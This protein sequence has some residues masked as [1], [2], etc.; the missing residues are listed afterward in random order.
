[1]DSICFL[2]LSR[3]CRASLTSRVGPVGPISLDL[4]HGEAGTVND[5]DEGN[6]LPEGVGEDDPVECGE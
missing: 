1:M 2:S 5:L 3:S 4:G 6:G